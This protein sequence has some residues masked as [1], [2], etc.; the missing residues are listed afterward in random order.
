MN[1]KNSFDKETEND[2]IFKRNLNISISKD[3]MEAYVTINYSDFEKCEKKEKIPFYTIEELREALNKAGITYG[4]IEENLKKCLDKNGADN[5]LVAKGIPS[6]DGIDD[7]LDIKFDVDKD[8]KKLNEDKSG[9]VDF[10]SI[11]AVNSVKEG[12][13]IAVRI[14]GK[15][16]IDG[17]DIKG[18]AVKGKNPKKIKIKAIQ[19]CKLID[20][21]TVAASIT[22]KPYMK[23]NAF[24]VYSVHEINE[25]VNLK[26]GNI[27][28]L[29]DIV[30]KG[31]VREGMKVISGNSVTIF[32][33]VLKAE[34]KAKSDIIIK[35]NVIASNIAAGGEDME[36][37]KEIE[38]LESLITYLDNIISCIE[39]IK[40]FNLF[41]YDVS[42]GQIIKILIENKF[43]SI[44]K[45]CLTLISH[46]VKNRQNDDNECEILIDI[47]KNKI[48]GLAPLNIK[49]YGELFDIKNIIK[50]R[51]LLLKNNIFLPANIKLSYCQDSTINSSGDIIISGKG[52]YVSNLYAK[53]SV[54][55]TEKNS[56]VRG[57]FIK[58]GKEIKC[59]NVG[60]NG[61]VT[62]R[63]TVGECGHIYTD[64]AYENTIF[65]I[66][67]REILLNYASKNVHVYLDDKHDIV[68][69]KLRL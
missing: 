48:L 60:S 39:E 69:D 43:K 67:Q 29:G 36:K 62:T 4:I 63:L 8:I 22:G 65:T 54:Y 15:E 30:I 28:F 64:I 34:I 9:R 68:V 2:F 52:T 61:G 27:K 25:D 6:I 49:H 16:S 41:G 23:N 45:T 66:G 47:I 56:V 55:F 18:K 11:G 1:I 35:G 44:P 14:P 31:N 51:I 58:A 12:D 57:G 40:K 19:G 42:D 10:K 3:N 26:T 46:I 5:I 33:N 24:Y 7:I 50:E 59:K 32:K 17:K 21:N 20:E 13:I 38:I 53:E 37:I